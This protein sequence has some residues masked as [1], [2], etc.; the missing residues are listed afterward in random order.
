MTRFLILATVFLFFSCTGTKKEEQ[1]E[2]TSIKAV[3]DNVITRLYEKVDPK[4]YDSIDDTFM[5]KFLTD[6]EKTTLATRYQYFKVDVPVT[7]SIMRQLDHEAPFWLEDS[8]FVKT[9]E[10]VKNEV[11]DYEV[12]QKDF[13]A[14]W[15]NLGIPG[16]DMNRVV[17]F[18]S[19]GPKNSNGEL[20]ISE[21]YPE[22]YSLEVFK[23]GAFTYHDW[24]G[25]K[26]TDLPKAL[27]GQV[28]F[29]TVRGR[30]R[31]A[32]VEGAFRKTIFPSSGQPDQIMLTWSGDPTNSV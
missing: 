9:D 17:Y 22:K 28:L 19:V 13:E 26:I 5:L 7:V 32:H 31:E 16:F 3:M 4:D 10:I 12:W 25:L 6:N 24:S 27:E 21:R 30:A 1:R 29:T 18:I 8:G 14:G 15:V 2:Q 23:K 11:Y 20:K